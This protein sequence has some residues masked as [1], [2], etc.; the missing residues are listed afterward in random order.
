[1]KLNKKTSMK[2]KRKYCEKKIKENR[3]REENEYQ[4]KSS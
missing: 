4:G 3:N 2:D 1:M